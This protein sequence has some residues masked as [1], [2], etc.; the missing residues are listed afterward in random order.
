[1]HNAVAKPSLA[2]AFRIGRATAA[3]HVEHC[4][5]VACAVCCSRHTCFGV[6]NACTLP[7]LTR[8]ELQTCSQLL[9]PWGRDLLPVDLNCS[10]QAD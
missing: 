7:T 3:V 5:C 6:I 8:Q 4:C 2:F 10:L 9:Q 1:M